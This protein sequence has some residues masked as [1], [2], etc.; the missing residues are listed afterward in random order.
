MQYDVQGSYENRNKNKGVKLSLGRE[1]IKYGGI[2]NKSETPDPGHYSPKDSRLYSP[3]SGYSMR[4]KLKE[5]DVSYMKNPGPGHCKY[6][7]NLDKNSSTISATGIYSLSN[8]PNCSSYKMKPSKLYD[9][10][11]NEKTP[12]PGQYDHRK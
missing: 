5:L 9:S 6:P 11:A 10:R 12:G 2:F 7:I 4:P 1:N 3:K 8:L